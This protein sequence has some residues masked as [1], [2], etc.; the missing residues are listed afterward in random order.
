MQKDHLRSKDQ[1]QNKPP[2]IQSIVNR[3]SLY[4]GNVLIA[5]V[6]F[7]EDN[8]NNKEYNYIGCNI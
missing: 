7:S 5:L 2:R 8:V 3:I 4:F 6:S 1:V